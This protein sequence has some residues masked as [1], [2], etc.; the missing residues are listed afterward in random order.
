M[1]F[2]IADALSF[3]KA[4]YLN[5]SLPLPVRMRAAEAALPFERP[6]LS[7]AALIVDGDFAERLERAVKR[8]Q[9]MMIE[10]QANIEGKEHPSA[11]LH[12]PPT[13]PDR[14]FRRI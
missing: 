13:P 4:V 3:M 10:A 9:P 7:A 12:P 5:Q 6:K 11:E 8:S 14:R 2:E 1:D